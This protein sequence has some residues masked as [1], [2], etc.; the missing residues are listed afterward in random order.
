[1]EILEFP[2]VRL[3]IS[4]RPSSA[5]S[6]V[7]RLLRKWETKLEREQLVEISAWRIVRWEISR[8]PSITMNAI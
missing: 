3:A 5:R 2:T 4:R 7:L 1:M 8:R 6:V